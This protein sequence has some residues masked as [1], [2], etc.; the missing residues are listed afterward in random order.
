MIR[1]WLVWLFV[2]ALALAGCA[3]LGGIVGNAVGGGITAEATET[4]GVIVPDVPALTV[5]H[6]AGS[7]TVRDGEADKITANLTK[8]SRLNDEA[9]AQAQLAE[10]VMSFTQSGTDVTLTIEEP[11]NTGAEMATEPTA[12]LE[13]LVPPGTNLEL[14][15][16]AGNITVEQPAGDVRINSGAG[17]ATVT[18]PADASFRLVIS[19]GVSAVQSDFEGVP[20]GGIA[21]EIDTTIGDNPTQTLTFDVGVGEVRLEEAR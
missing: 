3:G 11:G 9:A 21:T 6:F 5:D 12:E 2:L 1:K 8:Q 19:G 15:L 20:A 7:I 10:M 4:Q 17:N 18:L 13:L 16:G 14:T